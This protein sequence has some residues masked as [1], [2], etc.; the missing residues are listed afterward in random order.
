MPRSRECQ[1]GTKASALGRGKSWGRSQR[2]KEVCGDLGRRR[3]GSRRE[4]LTGPAS[5]QYAPKQP[6]VDVIGALAAT[7]GKID[8]GE[9]HTPSVPQAVAPP[10]RVPTRPLYRLFHHD[11][12]ERRAR[13][14]IT[15]RLRCG[16]RRFSGVRCGGKRAAKARPQR[17]AQADHRSPLSGILAHIAPHVPLGFHTMPELQ[18]SACFAPTAIPHETA[19]FRGAWGTFRGGAMEGRSRNGVRVEPRA[20]KIPI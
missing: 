10:G 19:H 8:A 17:W 5:A 9:G 12:N 6:R 3:G 13:A 15:C 20:S 14:A 1:T 11:G 16:A 18:L 4:A 7:L 2:I